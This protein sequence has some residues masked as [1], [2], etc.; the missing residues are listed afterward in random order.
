VGFGAYVEAHIDRERVA[1]NRVLLIDR[2][3]EFTRAIGMACL[4]G[5]IAVRMAEN[6]AE[7]VRYMLHFP[8]SAILVEASLLRL[9]APEQRRLFDM[10]APGVPVVVMV[11]SEAVTEDRVRL[12]L[13]GF[14]VVAKPFD[15]AEMLAK[16]KPL[17][18][19]R[20]PRPPARVDSLCG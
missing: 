15:I 14:A 5:G 10:V 20:A 3:S 1:M 13:Q 6:V 18:P 11:P 8:V 2:D 12:E 17:A 16:I 19:P 9:A 4:N 7:G